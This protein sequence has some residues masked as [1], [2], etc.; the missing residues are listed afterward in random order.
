MAN[1]A[2]FQFKAQLLQRELSHILD[3]CYETDIREIAGSV[4]P[5]DRRYACE[6]ALKVSRL[7][8][9]LSARLETTDD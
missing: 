2:L 1:K 7:M 8:E 3:I 5:Q 9:E 4:K 6:W